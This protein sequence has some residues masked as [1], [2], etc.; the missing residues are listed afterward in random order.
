[1]PVWPTCFW[2]IWPRW[3]PP[4]GMRLPAARIPMSFME[5]PSP[6]SAMAARVASE[7][8]STVSLS[9]CF[10]NLVIEMPRMKTSSAAM[11]VLL[12]GFEA[13]ADG[14]GAVVVG[15]DQVRGELHLHAELHVL[16]VGL[17]V[18]HVAA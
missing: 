17:G 6:A 11:S 5:M 3:P 1:M 8:R 16:G 14:L 7:A 13:E 18:D 2:S 12:Q 10:P 9:G 4:V 15:A